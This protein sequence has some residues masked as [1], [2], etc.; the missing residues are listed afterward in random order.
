[1][2]AIAFLA[3]AVWLASLHCYTMAAFALGGAFLCSM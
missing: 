3:G 2:V 1:M